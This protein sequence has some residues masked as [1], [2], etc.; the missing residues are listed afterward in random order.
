MTIL[1]YAVSGHA[2]EQLDRE[3]S[4]YR[5]KV[6]PTFSDMLGSLRLQMWQHRVYGASGTEVP[7]TECVQMLLRTLSA[8]A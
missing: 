5:Q 2:G 3:R 8:V 1:W 6:T 4:W 7:S